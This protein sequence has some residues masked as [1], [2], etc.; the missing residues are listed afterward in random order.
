MKIYCVNGTK[1]AVAAFPGSRLHDTNYSRL[2]MTSE[3]MMLSDMSV[4]LMSILD[5]SFNRDPSSSPAFLF[6]M[7]SLP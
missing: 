3:S 6:W 5:P 4:S 7:F 2:N 1:I